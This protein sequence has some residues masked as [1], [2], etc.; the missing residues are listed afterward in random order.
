VQK[1]GHGGLGRSSS[2]GQLRELGLDLAP[3]TASIGPSG[4]PG[5]V[6]G[7]FVGDAKG[8][9]LAKTGCVIATITWYDLECP[10]WGYAPQVLW[11]LG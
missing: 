9:S 8:R 6:V 11:V 10:K 7:K 4:E 5:E 2:R 3:R 1:V